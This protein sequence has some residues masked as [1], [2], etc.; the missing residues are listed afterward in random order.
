MAKKLC[1]I[2]FIMNIPRRSA[3]DNYRGLLI[4]EEIL[5]RTEVFLYPILKING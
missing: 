2:T 3:I 5:F 4:A 1:L